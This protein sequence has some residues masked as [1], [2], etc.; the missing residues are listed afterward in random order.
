MTRAEDGEQETGVED[1]G[2]RE[3]GWTKERVNEEG[4][5]MRDSEKNDADDEDDYDG[6]Y[7]TPVPVSP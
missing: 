1:D 2:G 5:D 7:M 3:A 4:E 6:G